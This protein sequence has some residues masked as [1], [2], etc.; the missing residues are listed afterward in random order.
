[1]KTITP[2]QRRALEDLSA[3]GLLGGLPVQVAEKDIHVTD[4]LE[5]L[6][7]LSV[8]HCHFQGLSRDGAVCLDDGIQLVFAGGTCL[9]KA[10]RLISRM[11]EDIDLKVIL[12]APSTSLKP[13]VGP[14]ARLRALHAAIEAVLRHLGFELLADAPQRPNPRIRDRHRYYAINAKYHNE[15]S[16]VGGLRPE[17]KLE[18]IHRHPRLNVTPASFGYMYETLAGIPSTKTVTLPCIHV[19]ETLAE[20]VLSLLRRCHWK[21]VGL[22]MDALDTALVRHVYDVHRIL[23]LQPEQLALSCTI[24]KA[25]VEGDAEEF[26]RRDPRF[27]ADPQAALTDTLAMARR[28]DELRR[29]YAEKVIPLIHEG[30]EVDY[31]SAFVAFERAADLLIAQL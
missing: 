22:Q 7:T 29:H 1:M 21:W 24:F 11:S 16:G 18:V 9:S 2:E 3:E 12:A 19:A 25:L 31:A 6:S 4:L 20:K 15:A 30:H 5:A 28:S 8:S 27:E 23:A 14:R 10:H 26:S 17:L 13:H